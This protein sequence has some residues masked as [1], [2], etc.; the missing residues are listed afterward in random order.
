MGKK[1]NPEK[2]SKKDQTKQTE[3]VKDPVLEAEA[4]TEHVEPKH[5]VKLN[6]S[7][8]VK[9]KKL[10]EKEYLKELRVLQIELVKMQ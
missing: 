7:A 9:P 4:A 1:K 8:D 10:N 3:P 2:K 5:E 6:Q